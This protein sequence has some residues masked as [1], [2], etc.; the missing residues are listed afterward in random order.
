MSAALNKVARLLPARPPG[1][2]RAQPR[3]SR[4]SERRLPL[5]AGSRRGVRCAAGGARPWRGRFF[6]S[7]GTSP[8]APSATA[9]PTPAPVSVVPLVS[10]P[11]VG[12]RRRSRGHCG[13]CEGVLGG[14]GCRRVASGCRRGV[15]GGPGELLCEIDVVGGLAGREGSEVVVRV[16]GWSLRSSEAG[17][18]IGGL[19]L[20]PSPGSVGVVEWRRVVIGVT[21]AAGSGDFPTG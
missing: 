5:G 1:R 6:T 12:G 13:L 15:W 14:W 9:R 20:K 18:G 2:L 8:K 10:A 4:E 16:T 7:T 17:A 11:G 3:K 19:L 21:G